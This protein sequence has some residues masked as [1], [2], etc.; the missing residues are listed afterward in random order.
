MY[1]YKLSDIMLTFSNA[2]CL[3]LIVIQLNAC[4]EGLAPNNTHNPDNKTYLTGTIRYKGGLSN[5]KYAKDS[6]TA[7]R[8]VAFKTIPDSAGILK[9][10]LAGNVFVSPKNIGESLPINVDSSMYSIEFSDVP[11]NLLY[12]AVAQ[13]YGADLTKQQRVIGLYTLTKDLT[14]PS[15]IFV[16]KGKNNN[17][18][19]EVDFQNIPPQPF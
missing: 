13:Q 2:L 19:I 6:L 1:H 4:Q 3:F 14:K 11:V 7:I 12:I 18:D 17:A 5:W 9:D 8:V 16:E 10:I 15:S